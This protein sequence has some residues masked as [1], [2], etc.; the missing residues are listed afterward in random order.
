M[1]ITV[2][3]NFKRQ[4]KTIVLKGLPYYFCSARTK[5]WGRKL[6]KIQTVEVQ[7]ATKIKIKT[8]SSSRNEIMRTKVSPNA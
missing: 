6:D 2:S 7:I 8:V 5:N 1:S 4:L 3:G